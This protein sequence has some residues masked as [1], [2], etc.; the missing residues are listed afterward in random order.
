MPGCSLIEIRVYSVKGDF[1]K[2]REDYYVMHERKIM[3]GMLIVLCKRWRR[4]FFF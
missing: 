3:G 1:R 2:K 4:F